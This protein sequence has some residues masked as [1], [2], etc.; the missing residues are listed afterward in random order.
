MERVVQ[1]QRDEKK[2]AQAACCPTP[3]YIQIQVLC[4]SLPLLL[5][6]DKQPKPSITETYENIAGKFRLNVQ[7][8]R[9][10]HDDRAQMDETVCISSLHEDYDQLI[11]PAGTEFSSTEDLEGAHQGTLV[12]N[13]SRRQSKSRITFNN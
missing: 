2:S 10:L 6:P 12:G 8:L 11:V 4:A 5:M 13:A 3:R 1:R 7:E 9:E